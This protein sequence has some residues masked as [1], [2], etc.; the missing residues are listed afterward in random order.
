MTPYEIA[1]EL[2]NI[3]RS[4]EDKRRVERLLDYLKLQKSDALSIE[5]HEE[6]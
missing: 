6:T 4:E 3:A 1:N 2:L 5:I